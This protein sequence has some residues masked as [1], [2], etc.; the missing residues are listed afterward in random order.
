MCGMDT[1]T[2]TGPNV[3]DVVTASVAL[4]ADVVAG[5]W[6][7][8]V[9]LLADRFADPQAAR[10]RFDQLAADTDTVD[11][12]TTPRLEVTVGGPDEVTVVGDRHM[13]VSALDLYMRVWLG[14]LDEVA[15]VARAWTVSGTRALTA[16]RL[17]LQAPGAWPDHPSASWGIRSTE[18]PDAARVAY[19]IWKALGGGVVARDQLGTGVV[20]TV[21]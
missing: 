12:A 7:A 3:A 14:Q 11:A 8:V 13:L 20:V 17:E 15:F 2:V 21:A 4:R 5:R 19:D 6:S 10:T 1:M 16:A 9:D 18:V